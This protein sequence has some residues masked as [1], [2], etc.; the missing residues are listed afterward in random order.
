MRRVRARKRAARALR[1]SY[2]NVATVRRTFTADEGSEPM[3]ATPMA[4]PA[5]HLRKKRTLVA[6]QKVI[7]RVVVP[8]LHVN[9]R[10]A[11]RF[12]HRIQHDVNVER[13]LYHAVHELRLFF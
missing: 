8:R 6:V 13:L 9:H 5:G 3:R 11:E 2:T 7:L 12:A 10:V 1:T 4:G